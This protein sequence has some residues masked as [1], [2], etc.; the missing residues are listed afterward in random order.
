M[1][2]TTKK[3]K[4]EAIAPHS[5]IIKQCTIYAQATAAY[6]GGFR[7]DPT[8]DFDYAG[9]AMGGAHLR[10]A[11]RALEKLAA[12]SRE[13]RPITSVELFAEAKVMKLLMKAKDN[14][15]EPEETAY[16]QRFAK[17][18]SRYL[19]QALKNGAEG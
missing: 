15:P 11:R 10:K 6:H 18:V 2:R 12:L 17:D 14:Q 3:A 19:K 8:G 16:V 9:S 1:K 5:E 7:T 4:A 13:K